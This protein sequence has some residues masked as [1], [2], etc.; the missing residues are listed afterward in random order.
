VAPANDSAVLEPT[1]APPGRT[2]SRERI[3]TSAPITRPLD[4]R[5]ARAELRGQVARLERSLAQ[6]FASA[7]PRAG[8][9]VSV[10]ASGGPRLLGLGELE[11]LRDDLH[12]RL[13]SARHE[14]ARR[15]AHEEHNRILL[16]KMLLEPGRY[17]FLRISHADL[18]ERGC[19]EWRVRPRFGLIGML[20]GWW[21]VKLSSGCPLAGGLRLPGAAPSPPPPK[22]QPHET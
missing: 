7:F 1:Q 22:H 11:S 17:K 19:G 16:E 2:E 6:A 8:I 12:E 5:E 15:S 13:S 4:E 14:L 9:D 21:Q 10:P 20:A 18:G 3:A